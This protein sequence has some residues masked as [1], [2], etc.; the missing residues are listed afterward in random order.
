MA[1]RCPARVTAP[2]P[3]RDA[4][5]A[6]PISNHARARPRLRARHVMENRMRIS[7]RNQL[8][9]KVVAACPLSLE[10]PA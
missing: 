4:L 9:G 5:P 8:K 10:Q 1:L 6:L 7:A 2:C 3:I